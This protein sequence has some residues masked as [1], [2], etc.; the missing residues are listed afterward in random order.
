V[1]LNFDTPTATATSAS[2]TS[3]AAIDADPTGLGT[4][5]RGA[6]RVDV[7]DKRM[8]NARADVNQ[9]LPLKYRWAW[10]KYLSGCANHWMPSE[11]SMQADI[12]LWR[13]PDGLTADER[14][15]VKRNLGFFA[16]SESLVA[17]NIVLA[18]YRHLTNP[19]CRQYLLRQAFE[20]AVHTHTFQY[21]CESLGLDEGEL[22]NAYREVPSITDKAAWALKHTRSLEDPDF[23]TG[24][25]AADQAF[26]R[27]LVAFYVVFEG[28]WFYTGFAQILALGRRGKMVG[29]RLETV[30]QF[31]RT[32]DLRANVSV[33]D[34]ATEPLKISSYDIEA[35]IDEDYKFSARTTMRVSGRREPQQ[36]ALL[37]LYGELHVDSLISRGQPLTFFRRDHFSPLWIRFPEPLAP[38]DSTDIRVVY[39][40]NLI[41]FGSAMEDFL[42]PWWDQRTRELLPTMDQWAYI[43]DTEYWFPRHTLG[44]STLPQRATMR[45]T[46][47]T[48]N[49]LKFASIGRLTDST[50][51]GNVRTTHWIS[52]LPTNQASFN[53]GKM[54]ELAIRDPRIPPVIVH[55][56]TDAHRVI[57]RLFPH[58]RNPGDIVG[59]DIA[60]SLGF[61]TRMYG[62]PPFDH[63]YATEIPYYHG[64]AFPGLIHLSWT[65]FISWST[66][67]ED[68][69]F[70]AHE[71]AHQWWYYGVEPASYRD[72]WMSEGFAEFSG[73]WYMQSILHDNDKYLKKLRTSR[74]DIRRERGKAAPLG[75]GTR[76][77]ESWRG[78]YQ[79]ITY[80]KGA[81]VLH[82]LRN[83]MLDTR[84]M[85]EDRFIALM[86]DFYSTY[87]G[88]RATTA[89]FQHVVERHFGQPMDWFFNEWVYGTA[90]PTYTFSWAATHD[91]TGVTAHVRVRQDDVPDGFAMYVPILIKFDEGEAIVRIL[92][93]GA[94]TDGT[95]RLPAQPKTMQLNPLESV[96]AEVKME[97]YRP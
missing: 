71:M 55:V 5:E 30:C 4:I 7:S 87:R 66:D 70:R 14:H 39:H 84:T 49:D 54:E 36:W 46:F 69:S 86:H 45:F 48:P 72:A 76:A 85:S 62:P 78:N 18:V 8:I 77:G 67:G 59:S 95:F 92:V 44:R 1:S 74:E 64:E 40:G 17:N 52:E 11:V 97:P 94:T 68:E 93:R 90:V 47:H 19:E 22:F 32:E 88:K 75:I 57:A 81:W 63:F 96:L 34:E 15:M 33:A 2:A 51:E 6:S 60:N 21:I 89:D 61:F 13:S 27:D 26:L 42:P 65:T 35:T 16:T 56:N 73:L 80:Q 29:Q 25:P 3:A 37:Q 12:A 9:L 23:R 41:V 31:Q 28:M 10:E 53:I 82:M 43:K 83:M 50:I 79:L 91:S 38:G 20:E 24:T 58:S